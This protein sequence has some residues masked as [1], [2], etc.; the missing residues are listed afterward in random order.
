M[1]RVSARRQAATGRHD[2]DPVG[3]LVL[4][5]PAHRRA[6]ARDAI[7][8][9]AEEVTVATRLRDRA[10]GDQQSW[11]ER[12]SAG[13]GVADRV[14]RHPTCAAVKGGC[15]A[16]TDHALTGHRPTNYDVL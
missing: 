5:Q 7:G 15:D 10:A 2:L 16:G 9:A 11:P 1:A 14:G 4:E 12:Q 8:L 6:D 3:T 13:D